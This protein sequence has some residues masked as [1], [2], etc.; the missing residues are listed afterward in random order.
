MHDSI[1]DQ[2][3]ILTMIEHRHTNHAR[4]FHR[5]PHDF[6]VLNAMTV[7]RDRHNARF[8]ERPDGREFFACEIF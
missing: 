4:I 7:I 8:R 2:I 6:V 3:V 1:A 5:A